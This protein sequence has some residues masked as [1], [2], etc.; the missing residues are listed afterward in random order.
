M[1]VLGG[2]ARRSVRPPWSEGTARGSQRPWWR[3]G[4]HGGTCAASTGQ[5]RSKGRTPAP[6]LDRRVPKRALR[7]AA[8]PL[9]ATRSLAPQVPHAGQRTP[10]CSL[11]RTVALAATVPEGRA[12]SALLQGCLRPSLGQLGHSAVPPRWAQH[13][14]WS[15]GGSWDGHCS[16]RCR[17][18]P[19]LLPEPHDMRQPWEGRWQHTPRDGEFIALHCRRSGSPGGSAFPPDHRLPSHT[20]GPGPSDAPGKSPPGLQVACTTGLQS[21]DRAVVL[22]WRL[23]RDALDKPVGTRHGHVCQETPL[24]A[25]LLWGHAGRAS[26]S[27]CSGEDFCVDK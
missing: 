4:Q 7:G 25:G 23:D 26:C 21:G 11:L 27:R 2:V 15:L 6:A 3:W 18:L 16:C 10:P 13:L 24:E 1:G 14:L 22:S 20:E 8:P 19:S 17:T 5:R 9:G 12:V